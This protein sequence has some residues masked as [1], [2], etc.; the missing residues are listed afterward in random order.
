MLTERHVIHSGRKFTQMETRILI[1]GKYGRLAMELAAGLPFE[2]KSIGRNGNSFY[3]LKKLKDYLRVKIVLE[4]PTIIINAMALNGMESCDV[5]PAAAVFSNAL[6]PATLA[7][8]S[9]EYNIP[10]IHFSSDYAIAGE[11]DP[12]RNRPFPEDEEY[13]SPCGIYGAT[14]RQGE[15]L[16]RN[17]AQKHLIFR[18]SSIYTH[19][20]L[21]GALGPVKYARLGENYPKVLDQVC[22]PTSLQAI[23][24]AIE[25]VISKIKYPKFNHWGTYHIACSGS[26]TKKEFA[27]RAIP[28]FLNRY[29]VRVLIGELNKPR[30]KFCLL[31]TDKF[32]R[33]FDHKMPSWEEALIHS[34]HQF[35]V[36][37]ECFQASRK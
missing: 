31:R 36:E 4:E 15:F 19:K 7:E 30:P 35:V 34:A 23:T 26:T 20:D 11:N 27:E 9:R 22:S 13:G 1:V 33:I 32:Q 25:T 5:F 24:A 16:V 21:D 10:L 2:K 37:Q 28:M 6:L 3:N 18:V 8:L 12:L 17:T 29:D 14:K